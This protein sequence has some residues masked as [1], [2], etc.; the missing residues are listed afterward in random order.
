MVVV[1]LDSQT[2]AILTG[3]EIETR[4]WVHAPEADELIDDLRRAAASAIKALPGKHGAGPLEPEI[5]SRAV[6]TAVAKVVGERTRRRPM[7]VPVI[8]DA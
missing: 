5:V 8:M 3:P 6:R 4:G 1:T 2:G 7:I